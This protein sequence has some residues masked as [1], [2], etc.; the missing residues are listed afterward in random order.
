MTDR[1]I[2]TKYSSTPGINSIS[3]T[4]AGLFAGSLMLTFCA[5]AAM[6]ADNGFEKSNVIILLTDDQGCGDL[7]VKRNPVLKT[8]HLD[9]FHE[10]SFRVIEVNVTPM[11]SPAR[12]HLCDGRDTYAQVPAAFCMGRS[13]AGQDILTKAGLFAVDR[14]R[15][16][17]IEV[18]NG[19]VNEILPYCWHPVSGF[20]FS[21]PAGDNH[22]N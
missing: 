12:I 15:E 9:R 17:F 1:V 14:K 11:R 22:V 8:P 18:D 4:V 6:K 2:N 10:L 3:L 7:S 16:L 13:M 5:P 20:G 19:G 21:K